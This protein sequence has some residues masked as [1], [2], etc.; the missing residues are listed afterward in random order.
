M[1][2]D[3]R[4]MQ[5]RQHIDINFDKQ[6]NALRNIKYLPSKLLEDMY[7][8]TA[9]PKIHGTQFGMGKLFKCKVSRDHGMHTY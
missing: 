1:T 5:W 2:L 9:I 7:F 4:V 3:N 8:K 6:I